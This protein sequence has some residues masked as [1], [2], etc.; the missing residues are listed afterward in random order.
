MMSF[1]TTAHLQFQE[2]IAPFAS[3]VFLPLAFTQTVVQSIR[4]QVLNL[5][6]YARLFMIYNYN[7]L[8]ILRETETDKATFQSSYNQK[9]FN[10]KMKLRNNSYPVAQ[11]LR[12]IFDVVEKIYDIRTIIFKSR[13]RSNY[14]YDKWIVHYPVAFLDGNI[15]NEGYIWTLHG[16]NKN[17]NSRRNSKQP[18]SAASETVV[19][20]QRP[21][22]MKSL[23][24][25]E[26]ENRF[27]PK[28]YV[29]PEHLKS[30]EANDV[31]RSEKREEI[32][33]QPVGCPALT[34]LFCESIQAV[35]DVTPAK[36]QFTDPIQNL[37]AI[38]QNTT[39]DV[40]YK[41]KIRKKP[42][43]FK[44][45]PTYGNYDL[46]RQAIKKIIIQPNYKPEGTIGPNLVRFTWHCC[47]HYD[48]V[49][50]TGGSS[51]GTMRFAQEFNDI[52]N[53]GLNTSKSYLDQVHESFPWIS[54]AD[55]YTLAGV[56]A[57]ENMG[58]PKIK[59]VPG[60]TD[61]I[62]AGK[63]PPNTRLPNAFLGSDHIREVFY[64]RL[65]FNA[66]E[67][68][69]LIGGGHGIG[70][71]HSRYSGFNGMWTKTPYKWDNS[72][73]TLLLNDEW[74]LGTVPETGVEQYYSHDKSLMM[75]N[76]DMEMLRC[77]EFRKW[78]DIFARDE[79]FF[80]Q[81]FADAFGKLIELGVIRDP[82]GIQRVKL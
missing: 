68:V 81:V 79:R 20:D 76:T 82:D 14:L 42:K 70:G 1:V 36:A 66:Q 61:C 51:G 58:G 33:S 27:I 50:G 78:V 12:H 21:T 53:T 43:D 69:A 28:S 38:G 29:I 5:K 65:G 40:A 54:Y 30:R 62:D 55:L 11:D 59:W 52:G 49:T 2:L 77:P 80:N 63:V 44:G 19:N 18:V 10:N 73:F 6:S 25:N 7:L 47:G 8:H 16:Y 23:G 9:I 24:L 60:R 15:A 74:K 3:V 75:L 48:R 72:F 4:F 45:H 26:L 56:V 46:L 71:C 22:A 41:I 39:K 35:E 67:T 17:P 32:S 37:I 64:D 13:A 57:I 31:S 34:N